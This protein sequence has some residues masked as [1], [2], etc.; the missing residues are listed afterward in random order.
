MTEERWRE[1]DWLRADDTEGNIEY[2]WRDK[3]TG[4]IPCPAQPASQSERHG[5]RFT[6]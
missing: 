4:G 3:V 1:C 6:V 5:E 2:E